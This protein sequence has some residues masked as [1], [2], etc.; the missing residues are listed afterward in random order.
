LARV[1]RRL[2]RPEKPLPQLK[3]WLDA[4]P[5]GPDSGLIWL[6]LCANAAAAGEA[7]RETA[8]AAFNRASDLLGDQPA[9]RKLAVRV[10]GLV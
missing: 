5:D 6:N 8:L 4:F 2:G 3:R 9:L 1:G 7:C 10:G